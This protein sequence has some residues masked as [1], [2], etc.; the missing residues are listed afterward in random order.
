MKHGRLAQYV[1]IFRTARA[2]STI[3]DSPLMKNIIRLDRGELMARWVHVTFLNLIRAVK[4]GLE[5]DHV[6]VGIVTFSLCVFPVDLPELQV[7]VQ[8][9]PV[10]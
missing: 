9:K 6:E 10:K 8:R 4:S 7:C 1:K 3:Q 5:Y 2:S